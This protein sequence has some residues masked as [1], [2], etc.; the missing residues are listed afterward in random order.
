MLA[1]S[2]DTIVKPKGSVNND[3]SVAFCAWARHQEWVPAVPMNL[4]L[5]SGLFTLRSRWRNP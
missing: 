5:H 2:D 4:A 1:A 3:F